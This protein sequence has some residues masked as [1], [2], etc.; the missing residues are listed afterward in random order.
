VVAPYGSTGAST[1]ETMENGR[2]RVLRQVNSCAGREQVA[3]GLGRGTV[4]LVQGLGTWHPR[5]GQTTPNGL[6]LPKVKSRNISSF[7]TSI[8]WG[9]MHYA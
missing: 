7:Q 8:H 9:R 6:I 3:V 1:I 5:I 2:R 4:T